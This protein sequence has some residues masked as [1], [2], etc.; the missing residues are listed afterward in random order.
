[1]SVSKKDIEQLSYVELMA[2]LDEVNRP[3]GGKDSV[4]RVVQNTF[5]T[6]SSKAL[7]VGCNTGY[8][9]FEIAHLVGCKVTG[10][11]IDSSMI[12]TAEKNRKKDTHAQLISFRKGDAMRLPFKTRTFDLVM[13]GGSTAFVDDK[14][15]AIK[16]YKRVTKQWGFVAD[17]N[18]FYHTKP[19]AI[20]LKKL[21]ALLD[22]NIQPWDKSYWLKI[23]E[24]ADLEPYY[25]YE[26]KMSKVSNRQ[27]SEYCDAMIR[28]R[29][30]NPAVKKIM[31]ARLSEAMTLFNENHKYLAYGVF[32][33][34]NRPEKEQV[35]LF[36]A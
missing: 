30:L 11:D 1:M 18:F 31:Y 3:P 32:V 4:R 8:V 34:R 27:V 9:T 7:D 35:S 10:L 13:S 5:L 21:N 23:Y 19:P 36:G 28:H 16:E 14:I 26:G 24:G 15:N 2:F 25:E 33:Y 12:K 29:K 22:I 17:V 6:P 20:L